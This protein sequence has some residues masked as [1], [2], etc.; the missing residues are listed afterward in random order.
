MPT[1][2][3]AF[4]DSPGVPS[5]KENVT[6]QK[7]PSGKAK[8]NALSPCTGL[9]PTL[10][11]DRSVI[12]RTDSV[13]TTAE[14]ICRTVPGW[15]TRSCTAATLLTYCEIQQSPP[16]TGSNDLYTCIQP[17]KTRIFEGENKCPF[18]QNARRSRN[19]VLQSNKARQSYKHFT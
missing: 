11:E 5:N 14:E 2:T 18:P 4:P 1:F 6:T 15:H 12:T 16:V 9:S 8:K 19:A 13:L 17:R 7:P 3:Q 10:L